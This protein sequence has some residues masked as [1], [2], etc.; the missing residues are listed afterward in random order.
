[1]VYLAYGSNVNPDVMKNRCPDSK[2]LGKGV[3][4]NH[5]LSFN[6]DKFNSY[7]TIEKKQQS[8]VPVAIYELSNKDVKK[9][10]IYEGYPRLYSKGIIRFVSENKEIDH[11]LVYIM[12]DFKKGMPTVEYLNDVIEG[13]KRINLDTNNLKNAIEESL[14][15]INIYDISKKYQIKKRIKKL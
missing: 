8:T 3:I 11:G 2:Y 10:D 6:G 1:M 12:N 7:L 5:K 4:L 15:N 9:L 14:K 13:Y